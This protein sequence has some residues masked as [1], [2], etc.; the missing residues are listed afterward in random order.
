MRRA[1]RSG[2]RQGGSTEGS[3]CAGNQR[4]MATSTG[5]QS[6]GPEQWET[7]RTRWSL[8]RRAGKRAATTL[9]VSDQLH[10]L[11]E[12]SEDAPQRLANLAF[13]RVLGINRDVPWPVHFTSRVTA[14]PRIRIHPSVKK[15][16]ANSGGCYI[17]GGSGIEIGE[18]TVFG[19]GVKIVSANHSQ[20]DF[21][22][23][24]RERPIRI[25]RGCWIGA[26]AVILPGVFLGDSVVVG[27]GAVVTHDFP[28]PCVIAGVPA[29]VIRTRS[30]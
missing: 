28:E 15:S 21:S 16:F 4:V 24:V 18:G 5:S 12:W 27:A 13:Q 3:P 19:P 2:V 30:R 11:S 20:D 7:G 17:Q 10:A 14:S 1:W 25:G 26:N 6:Q 23:H 22:E 29:A 9:G 8:A